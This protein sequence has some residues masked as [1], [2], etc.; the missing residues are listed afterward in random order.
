MRF[1]VLTLF[2]PIFSGYLEQSLLG[3]AIERGCL[4]VHVHDMR[5]WSTGP[6]NKVDDRPYGGG[7]GMVLQVGPVVE[8]V[9]AVR[10]L[11]D[12][13]AELILLT[14]Q[15]K[16]LNQ[17]VVEEIAEV[18]RL[19]VICGRYEGFDQRII[20]ILQP[21]EL[22]IGDYVLNGGEVAA[23]VLVDAVMRLIPGVLGDELSNVDDSFSSG[24]RLLE[25]PQYTRPR[26]YRGWDVPE[27]LLSGD[28]EAIAHWR[29]EQTVNRTKQ[30]R[31][32]LLREENNPGEESQ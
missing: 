12:E 23:M 10:R 20:D 27:V 14:P 4:D 19:I 16:T 2:P 3:K 13:P 9:E 6:H 29:A 11:S 24:N 7:P 17:R 22:S 18:P 5:D 28:H 31:G 25:F 8:C 15:G 30:R 21:T 1:D 32:D 26:D